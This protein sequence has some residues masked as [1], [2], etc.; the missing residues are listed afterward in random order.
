[1]HKRSMGGRL[2]RTRQTVCLR[3]TMARGYSRDLMERESPCRT[4]TDLRSSVRVCGQQSSDVG[5]EARK[6]SVDCLGSRVDRH[7]VYEDGL[8]FDIRSGKHSQLGFIRASFSL[9]FMD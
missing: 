7:A 1:M 2:A 8:V 6:R 3:P 4:D 5:L 9:K